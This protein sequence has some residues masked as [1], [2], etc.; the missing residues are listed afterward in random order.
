MPK[1]QQPQ[2]R[3]QKPQENP[4]GQFSDQEM[5]GIKRYGEA[6]GGKPTPFDEEVEKHLAG[7]EAHFA[8]MR[9]AQRGG[10]LGPEQFEQ[11]QA[12]QTGALQNLAAGAGQV[13]AA[14][15]QAG[16]QPVNPPPAPTGSAGVTSPYP[17]QARPGAVPTEGSQP[18]QTEDQGEESGVP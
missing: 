5:E 2:Q 3:Q 9:A 7:H 11:E 1:Q 8:K 12:K 15:A 10:D 13:Q 14:Q 18:E 17:A 4:E 16:Q 6:L